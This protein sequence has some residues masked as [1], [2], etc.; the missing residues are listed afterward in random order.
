MRVWR[1]CRRPHARF[2]GEGARRFGGRWNLRGTAVV[3]TSAT[4]SLAVLEY[5]VNLEPE[6]A[7]ADLVL[8]PADLPDALAVDVPLERLPADWRTAPAPEALARIGT[9]WARAGRSAV[10]SVPSAI[11][12]VERNYLL[13]PAHRDF[14]AIVVG[15]PQPFSLDPRTWKTRRG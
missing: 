11:L 1:L 3:Y 13:D 2:D 6:D 9:E 14:A 7:P 5:L 15:R 10:L 8:V 4:A 12:P